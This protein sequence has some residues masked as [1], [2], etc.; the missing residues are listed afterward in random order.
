MLEKTNNSEATEAILKSMVAQQRNSNILIIVFIVAI[1]W[2]IGTRFLN[3]NQSYIES[4]EVTGNIMGSHIVCPG[5]SLDIIIHLHAKGSG[6]LIRD[7][8][9]QSA[10]N[11]TLVMEPDMRYPFANLIDQD[12]RLPWVVPK[13]YFNTETGKIEA[14]P[15][16]E[17]LRIISFTGRGNDS[18]VF[19]MATLGFTVPESCFQ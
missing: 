4:I 3:K 17:F 12:I 13:Y 9:T 15:P 6:T 19:D 14:F 16:G 8:S 1:A 2:S 18:T 11:K 10:E 7:M 5:D